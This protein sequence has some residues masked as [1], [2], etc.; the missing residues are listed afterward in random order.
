MSAAALLVLFFGGLAAGTVGSLFGLGGGIILIPLLVLV[1]KIPIHNAIATSLVGVIATSSAT[2]SRNVQRGMA[3]LRLASVLEVATVIGAI[4]GGAIAGHLHPRSLELLFAIA[5]LAMVLPMALGA[6]EHGR[7]ARVEHAEGFVAKLG[8]TYHDPAL[9]RDVHYEITRFPLAM[10]ISSVAG[11]LSGLLGVGGGILKVP[12]LSLYCGMPVKAAAATSNFMIGV[13]A[14]ASAFVYYGRGDIKPI[15]TAC[16]V[17][18]VFAGSRAGLRIAERTHSSLLR[19]G[20]ALLMF[21]IAAQ[22][23]WKAFA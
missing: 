14:V 3:N 20:F 17:L 7:A 23:A 13:T 16:A 10:G 11:L 6:E 9:D 22:M 4:G 15:V 5:L 12:V 19:R 8:A 21:V 1:L 2:A 18:G